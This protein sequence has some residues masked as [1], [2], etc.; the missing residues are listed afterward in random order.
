MHIPLLTLCTVFLL[1]AIRQ[2]GNV[3]LQI[4]QIMA[5]G[6]LIVLTAGCISPTEALA[7]ID[8]DVMLFL[9]GM[10]VVGQA[11]EESGYLAHVSYRYFKRA[12]DLN[13]LLFLVICHWDLREEKRRGGEEK[14]DDDVKMRRENQKERKDNSII[15]YAKSILK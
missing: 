6:A 7:A 11:L 5:G 13:G 1:I 3:R 10:F 14:R 2:I 15:M 8:I 4:W 12:S 9:F